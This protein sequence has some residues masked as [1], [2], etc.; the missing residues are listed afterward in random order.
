MASPFIHLCDPVT[1]VS[2]R[3]FKG[4]GAGKYVADRAGRREVQGMRI[5]NEVF[6]MTPHGDERVTVSSTV[7]CE[8]VS[9]EGRVYDRF[10]LIPA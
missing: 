10:W 7:L 2:L 4:N 8:M 6:A 5:K 1:R 3:S 9:A